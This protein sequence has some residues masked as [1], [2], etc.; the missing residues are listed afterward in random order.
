MLATTPASNP[1]VET[2]WELEAQTHWRTALSTARLDPKYADIRWTVLDAKPVYAHKGTSSPSWHLCLWRGGWGEAVG[3]T[4]MKQRC[5]MLVPRLRSTQRT[6]PIHHHQ[7][8]RSTRIDL[9]HRALRPVPPHL[10]SRIMENELLPIHR[11]A[12]LLIDPPRKVRPSNR[13]VL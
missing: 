8:H 9:H 7:C 5:F 10:R 12:P 6:W 4:K 3:L 11:P 2:T 1:P 13:V